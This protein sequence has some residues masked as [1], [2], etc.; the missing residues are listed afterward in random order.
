MKREIRTSCPKLISDGSKP[1]Q[2]VLSSYESDHIAAYVNCHFDIPPATEDFVENRQQ[3]L[4]A[5]ARTMKRHDVDF[6]LPSIL[7]KT[8]SEK[9]QPDPES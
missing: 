3:V 7:Y 9:R 1:F 8:S 2:A 5:I 6:A 4:L